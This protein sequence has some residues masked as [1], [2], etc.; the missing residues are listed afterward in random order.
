MRFAQLGLSNSEGIPSCV[1]Y[2]HLLRHL[3]TGRIDDDDKPAPII[4]E[5]VGFAVWANGSVANEPAVLAGL[6]RQAAFSS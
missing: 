2:A 4:T 5:V 6:L 3:R 1:L